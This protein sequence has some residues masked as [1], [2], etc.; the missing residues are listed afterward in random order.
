MNPWIELIRNC[1]AADLCEI[2]EQVMKLQSNK[3]ILEALDAREKAEDM[4]KLELATKGNRLL[5]SMN[6]E[7][8]E[9]IFSSLQDINKIL[10]EFNEISDP[11]PLFK[12]IHEELLDLQKMLV[13]NYGD[14]MIGK[15]NQSNEIK[16]LQAAL[17]EVDKIAEPDEP[18]NE[19]KDYLTKS[20]MHK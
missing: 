18:I 13:E 12:E 5:M 14:L 1:K 6:P 10:T 9:E 4:K 15:A 16:Y 20:I 2:R 17:A 19:L 11:P 3:E 8:E 7:S